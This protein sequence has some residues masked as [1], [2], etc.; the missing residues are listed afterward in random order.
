MLYRSFGSEEIFFE[1]N[2]LEAKKKNCN[3]T[4]HVVRIMTKIFLCDRVYRSHTHIMINLQQEGKHSIL[5]KPRNIY[6]SIIG[7]LNCK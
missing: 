3:V 5:T 1:F 6:T 2:R 7:A 4:V